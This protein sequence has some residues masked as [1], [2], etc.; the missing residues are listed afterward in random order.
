MWAK[1]SVRESVLTLIHSTYSVATFFTDFYKFHFRS[2]KDM[3]RF[4]GWVHILYIM[5]KILSI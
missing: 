4:E 2:K 3:S 1:F 5:I